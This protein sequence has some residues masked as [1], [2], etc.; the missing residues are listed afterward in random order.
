MRSSHLLTYILIIVAV[1]FAGAGMAADTGN[2]ASAAVPSVDGQGP[3]EAAG[4]AAD[5][6]LDPTAGASSSLPGASESPEITVDTVGPDADSEAAAALAGEFSGFSPSGKPA[7]VIRRSYRYFPALYNPKLA[8]DCP[9]GGVLARSPAAESLAGASSG[10]GVEG[11]APGLVPPPA[12]TFASEIPV[13]ANNQVLA[14]YG[15]PFSK[16]MGILGEYSKEDL[17][18]LLKGYAKLYD[19]ANGDAGVIPAF[20]LIYG[21]CWPGGDIGYLKDSVVKDYIEYAASQGMMVFVDHQIGR[22]TVAEA[23]RRLLPYLKYP[24]VH[25]ALDPEWRTTAPMQ[26]IGSITAEEV[27]MAQAMIR[28]YMDLQGIPGVKILVVHQFRSSMIQGRDRV[29]ANNERVLLVHTADG[30]GPPALK[31]NAYALNA[32]AANMPLKG[33]KL[34]FRTTVPG[35]GYDE[36]LLTPPEVLSLTPRPAL[37]IYQ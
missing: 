22:F 29:R 17:A 18:R 4:M 36:P 12:S 9:A 37:I 13:L 21:T 3:A 26:E 6:A 8:A 2:P 1:L 32:Q 19:E 20:Y 14:F 24:N 16:R 31:K 11:K 28:D 23:V 25:I 30:F 15:H 7:T 5:P 10:S 34:F 33:F 27:N 35:A